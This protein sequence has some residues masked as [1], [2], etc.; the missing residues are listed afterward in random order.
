MRR[1]IL[2]LLF[3]SLP[4][5]AQEVVPPPPDKAMKLK[6]SK[7]KPFDP[8]Q[9]REAVPPAPLVIPLPAVRDPRAPQKT[10]NVMEAVALALQ[11]QPD[12]RVARAALIQAE[13][14]TQ[15]QR[16]G[17]LPK[18]T[19][20]S[21]Y[22]HSSTPNNGSLSGV[23][24]PLIFQSL[25]GPATT[26]QFSN[27]VML[28]QLL[29]DFGHTRD[30]ILQADLRQQSAAAAVLKSENDA[31]LTVKE[32][33]YDLLLKKRLLDIS[34]ADLTNR[35]EQL[36]MARALF[37]AGNKSPGDV[38][39]AQTSVSNS[40]FSLNNGRRDLEL[41]RQELAK[42]IG[43]APLTPLFV[44]DESEPDLSNKDPYYLLAQAQKQRP[45]IL[46][47]QRNVKASEAG[48][49]AASTTNLPSVSTQA[50]WN[51]Q[52]AT[53]AVQIP[54]F[55]LQAAIQFNIYDGGARDAA[56]R[57]A[58]GVLA[59]NQAELTRTQLSAEGEVTASGLQLLTA[60]RNL[61]ATR[62]AVD[63]AREGVRIADGRYR[64]ALGTL[65]DIFD[66]QSALVLA[67][68]NN[69]NSLGELNLARARLRHALALPFDEGYRT[70][71]TPTGTP[72]GSPGLSPEGQ[73]GP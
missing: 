64:A 2:L 13:G 16:V 47:A 28:S 19:L 31:A 60:E 40:V 17:L 43:L 5:S 10:I 39:R 44:A 21:Q 7:Y 22:T 18:L 45:D 70:P 73:P 63:S 3:V 24:T 51:Y 69:V 29:F 1:A 30:L 68:Q 20:Q 26:D 32:K 35:Q 27:N 12:V 52:G 62:A 59:N 54:T 11:L 9:T 71:G 53:N 34:Q 67:Q 37:Q 23:G 38:V 41:A 61:E 36:R 56:I 33:F 6:T 57:I 55:T 14:N 48:L 42:S 66:A 15:Q 49:Q 65:T 25:L 50:G 8:N 4:L 58:E 46:A 72:Q